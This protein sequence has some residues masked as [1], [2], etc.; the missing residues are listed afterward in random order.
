MQSDQIDNHALSTRAR[1]ANTQHFSHANQ[2]LSEGKKT[3]MHVYAR[4]RKQASHLDFSS[5]SRTEGIND[6]NTNNP[7]RCSLVQS[8]RK[9]QPYRAAFRCKLQI[10]R[11]M[12]ITHFVDLSGQSKTKGP[13]S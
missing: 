7:P 12:D 11:I 3:P 8:F 13:C 1:H 9:W 5:S 6:S 2:Q 4:L 10:I